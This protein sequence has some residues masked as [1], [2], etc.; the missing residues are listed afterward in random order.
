MIFCK[1]HR[2][3]LFHILYIMALLL[4]IGC[5]KHPKPTED[6]MHTVVIP[7]KVEKSSDSTRHARP[8]EPFRPIEVAANDIAAL[9]PIPYED[10]MD[11]DC[12]TL[13][14][15]GSAASII[16]AKIDEALYFYQTAQ[17]FWQQGE[18]ENALHALD[19]A[20][21][22][23]IE[24]DSLDLPKL[25]QQKDDLRF[26][27]SKR[28]LEIYASRHFTAKGNHNA[29]PM[30]INE[31]V[32]KEIDFFTTGG[33]RQFFI[34]SYVRSGRYRPFILE[35]IRK[36][37]LPE[38][39]SWLPLIESGFQTRALSPARALGLWQFIPSTGYKFGLK[40]NLHVDERLDPHKSTL[41]AIEYLKELHNI[42]GDWMTVLAAYNCGEGR[43]L[44]TIRDQNINY[45]DDF[46]DLYRKLPK[47]TARYVPKFLATVHIIHNL[48]QY[49][50]TD[51]AID[52][53][54][55]FDTVSIARAVHLKHIAEILDASEK[56][57]ADL[58]PELR[59][60]RLPNE[61]YT[62]K[63]PPGTESLILAG[64]DNIEES[65]VQPITGG[66]T[67]HRVRPGETL[68]TIARRYQTSVDA[69][70]SIN[71]IQ[72]TNFIVAGTMLK[73]PQAGT[74][75]AQDE[76]QPKVIT[77]EVRRG[78]SL[79]TL[80]NR[81]N[82]TTKRIQEL[83]ALNTANLNI[84]QTLKIPAGSSHRYEVYNVKKG[85]SPSLIARRFNM[86]LSDFYRINK[87]DKNSIIYPG[88]RVF[89][90]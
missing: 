84:G 85:D 70:A 26:M 3:H 87:L 25:T 52:P 22:L 9:T 32:Q 88:Q 59:Y 50:M 10:T 69:L 23:I 11:E 15:E 35:E 49:D 41:A 27:I 38:D 74:T 62:L 65:V 17:D 33:G 86:E 67:H 16:Q 75:A 63:I 56:E 48:E 45:L 72:R 4:M 81:Y 12:E 79:W 18:L 58:N 2:D 43:V 28:I 8:G 13:L 73:V 55:V 1:H 66:V 30:I 40:R 61:E 34:N 77:Y 71:N 53:P 80:A 83:N 14:F 54:V 47:E 21:A 60:K 57:L 78:D 64:I 42:F 24:A 90:Q 68:S 5:A 19:S 44:R 20:Y 7:D 39:L 37:G 82:T 89:V 76:R 31:D 36:A 46:W 51:I 6:F 29:I